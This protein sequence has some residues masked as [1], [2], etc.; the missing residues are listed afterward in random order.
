[1]DEIQPRPDSYD[2]LLASPAWQADLMSLNS[3]ILDS[4]STAD[5]PLQIGGSP[6][7]RHMQS[8]NILHSKFTTRGEVKRRRLF[9]LARLGNTLF[10][11]GV[12]GGHGLLLEKSANPQLKC[13]GVD[14]CQTVGVGNP[15]ADIYCPVAMRWLENRFP[16]NMHFMIGSTSDLL[17]DFVRDNAT[18]RIDILR[19]DGARS[20]YFSDFMTLR[21]LLH[22]DSYI[23]F[24]DP[25]WPQCRKT[26][27]RLMESGILR[28]DPHFSPIEALFVQDPVMRLA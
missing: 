3:A 24:D 1:M 9:D 26:V 12:N 6:F 22:A 4:L 28:P 21:P 15:R 16:G 5:A 27:E 8:Q 2:A 23:V 11:I 19:I 17:P 14:I 10:E 20:L 13:Y 7:Y 18:L 25:G